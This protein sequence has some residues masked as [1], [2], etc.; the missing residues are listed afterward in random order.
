[1]HSEGAVVGCCVGGGFWT[2]LE[3]MGVFAPVPAGGFSE[4]RPR[5]NIQLNHRPAT[6]LP[7]SHTCFNTLELPAYRSFEQLGT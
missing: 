2:H 3:E 5:L 1:M 4:L 6:H 7:V